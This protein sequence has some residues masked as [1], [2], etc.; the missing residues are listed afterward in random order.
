ENAF[1]DD[2][3]RLGTV[4][5][6]LHEALAEGTSDAFLPRPA[7][8]AHIERWAARAKTW[9][10]TALG[11]LER[12]LAARALPRERAP[13]AEA[14]AR[15]RD[16]YLAS[17]DEIVDTLGDDAGLELRI[18]GDYHLGQVLHTPD[19]RFMIIDFEGEPARTLAERREKDSP[20]R[21]VAGMLR[22]FAYAAATLGA[23]ATR[24]DLPTREIRIGRWERDTR[25]AFLRGY[26]GESK[27]A[28]P[29]A[30]RASML[31]SSVEHTRALIRLFETEKAFYE[32]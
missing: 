11:D 7:S 9:I 18:H 19:G 29:D 12:Q 4:T 2:A 16:H 5:R 3:Q 20:L 27:K 6:E 8:R 13:E 25:E 28:G 26:L 14:L 32:L 21:D 15:R 30:S 22:S 24:L 23:A 31:P 1:L 10:R 17:V